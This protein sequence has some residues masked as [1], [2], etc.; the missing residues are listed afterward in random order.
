[1]ATMASICWGMSDIAFEA[2]NDT[3]FPNQMQRVFGFWGNYWA[4]VAVA[5]QGDAFQWWLD[6]CHETAQL[7]LKKSFRDADLAAAS[8]QM[9]A[10]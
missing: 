9:R 6:F 8:T 7:Q 2:S 1:M 3:R 10:A 5:V 4:Q